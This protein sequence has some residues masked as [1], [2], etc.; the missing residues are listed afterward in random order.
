M[1]DDVWLWRFTR[2][3]IKRPGGRCDGPLLRCYATMYLH[4]GTEQ[5]IESIEAGPP[6][7]GLPE[8]IHCM[9]FTG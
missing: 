1:E 4:V 9:I 8:D 7:L 2:K 5:I 6:L 3:S